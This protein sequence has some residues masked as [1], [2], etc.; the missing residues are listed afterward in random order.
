[1]AHSDSRRLLILPDGHL[2][3]NVGL[4]D[5][6]IYLAEWRPTNDGKYCRFF[7]W[8]PLTLETL[9]VATVVC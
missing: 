3:A 9:E 2:S 1:M 5:C 6:V 7:D 4:R 8:L